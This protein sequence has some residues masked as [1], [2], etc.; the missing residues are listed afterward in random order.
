M[1]IRNLDAAGDWVF[2]HGRQDYLTGEPAIELNVKTRLLSFLNDCFWATDFGI[3]WW[4]LLG[5]RNPQAQS[6]IIV[7][8]RALLAQSYGIVRINTIEAL[9]DRKTRRLTVRANVDTIFSRGVV[10]AVQP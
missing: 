2:G 7:Q 6:N 8:V 1:T 5:S 4:N 9:T 3:D 10:L